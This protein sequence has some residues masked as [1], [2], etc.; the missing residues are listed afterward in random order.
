ME[1]QTT[2][3]THLSSTL[4]EDTIR[5][6]KVFTMMKCAYEGIRLVSRIEV[7]ENGNFLLKIFISEK[8]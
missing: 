1:R 4:C 2:K 6:E 5:A 3:L 7:T 8:T